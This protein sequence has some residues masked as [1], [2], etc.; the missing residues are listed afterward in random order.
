MLRPGRATYDEM[1]ALAGTLE[2][3]YL[4]LETASFVREAAE[5]YRQRN[6]VRRG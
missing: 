1:V 4:A 2:D 6:L 5:V 3:Q